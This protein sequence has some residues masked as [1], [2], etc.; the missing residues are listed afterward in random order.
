VTV[1]VA[2]DRE[3]LAPQFDDLITRTGAKRGDEY[4]ALDLA[5]RTKA[6]RGGERVG[7]H[8]T[9]VAVLEPL[10]LH[11]VEGLVDEQAGGDRC[12]FPPRDGEH[13]LTAE[14][15]G[16]IER[17]VQPG[18]D[19]PA[20][21]GA[22]SPFLPCSQRREP[23]RGRT[24]GDEHRYRAVR[25]IDED[26]TGRKR[27][28]A[29]PEG[30]NGRLGVDQIDREG[31]ERRV[32]AYR[33]AMLH[34]PRGRRLVIGT[35]RHIHEIPGQRGQQDDRDEGPARHFGPDP[36]LRHDDTSTSPWRLGITPRSVG[37]R[38]HDRRGGAYIA[39]ALLD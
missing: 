13:G 27:P 3:E 19:P 36:E 26:D 1:A 15:I 32:L 8:R 33:G 30:T 35:G 6:G 7:Q 25:V 12:R 21:V 2:A 38:L 11:E 28:A 20:N 14:R 16:E 24:R 34:H 37:R 17:A 23:R 29:G 31:V 22:K 9:R 5:E 4:T 10:A 39:E 18:Q